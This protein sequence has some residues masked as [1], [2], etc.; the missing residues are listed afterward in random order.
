MAEAKTKVKSPLINKKIFVR[1]IIRQTR[2]I[3][4]NHSANWQYDN[5]V[6]QL[7]PKRDRN[8]GMIPSPL[9]SEER[10]FF[11][12]SSRYN[13]HGLTF[14]QGDLATNAKFWTNFEVK[15]RKDQDG[16][17][18]EDT[19]LLTLNLK[20]AYD[21]FKYKVLL[22]NADSKGVVAANLDEKY[23]RKSNK[24]VLVEEDAYDR[25]T[26]IKRD[27][28]KEANKFFYSIDSSPE[29]MKDFLYVCHYSIKDYRKVPEE[30]DSNW[31]KTEIQ[32]L[33]DTKLDDVLAIIKDKSDYKDK[34][35]F[36]KAIKNGDIT[37]DANKEFR[38]VDGTWLGTTIAQALETLNDEANQTLLLKIKA[39]LEKNKKK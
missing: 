22:T 19:N 15:I 20:D 16:V 11:E 1:P 38:A 33:I 36:Q 4:G 14:K 6:I 31:L 12:D 37:F 35:M 30:V 3:K 10:A 27:K 2:F 34:V 18:K 17:M 39:Q 24:I 32:K 28:L 21:Y 29:D 8:S 5:T 9:T 7:V 25:T 26:L 23:A 13:E